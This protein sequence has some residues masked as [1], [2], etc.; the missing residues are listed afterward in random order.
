MRVPCY[1]FTWKRPGIT[2]VRLPHSEINGSKR[3]CRYPLLIAAC[4][5]LHRLLAPRHPLCALCSL[6]NLIQLALEIFM[7]TET[8]GFDRSRSRY[9]QTQLLFVVFTTL[10][11]DV[12]EPAGDS[13]PL[14]FKFRNFFPYLNSKTVVFCF[15]WR[16]VGLTG[17]EPVTLRLSSA[18]S[19]QLSYRPNRF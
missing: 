2:T 7:I 1:V 6:I 5:V 4:Y 10:Y 14:W 11:V 9:F 8:L 18:C 19:N 16:R 17:L 12:K 15:N 3:I 13:S